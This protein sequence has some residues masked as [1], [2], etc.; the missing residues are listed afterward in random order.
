VSASSSSGAGLCATCRHARA[1]ASPRASY[2]RCGRSDL[3]PDYPRYPRLPVL[4]CV[5][6]EAERERGDR[7]ESQ[8]ALR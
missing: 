8:E 4:H 7:P 3:D 6:Y 5:G 2:L 1:V